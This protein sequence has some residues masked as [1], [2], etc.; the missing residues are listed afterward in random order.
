M[1]LL[2]CK[3]CSNYNKQL[4]FLKNGMKNLFKKKTSVDNEK[5]KKLENEILKKMSGFGDDQ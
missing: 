1:H 4:L 3:H 2:M 5:I